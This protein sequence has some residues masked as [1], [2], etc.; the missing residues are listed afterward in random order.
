MRLWGQ[1]CPAHE[2]GYRHVLTNGMGVVLVFMKKP[3]KVSVHTI[4]V[5]H[6]DDEPS[7]SMDSEL[8]QVMSEN[9][10]A[11]VPNHT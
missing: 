5:Q 10:K 9:V 6:G 11:N 1:K 4:Y 2:P 8:E 3:K 7:R